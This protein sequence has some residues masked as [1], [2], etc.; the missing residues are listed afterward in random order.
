MLVFCVWLCGCW[1]SI[2]SSLL[3]KARNI[4]MRCF[5][6]LFKLE[7]IVDA[8]RSM[9]LYLLASICASG[10]LH[11]NRWIARPKRVEGIACAH[12]SFNDIIW[13]FATKKKSL[14]FSCL[15]FIFAQNKIWTKIRKNHL[16]SKCVV[17]LLNNF[18]FAENQWMK[19]V[20]HHRWMHGKSN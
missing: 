20:I 14:I 17:L 15:F 7:T 5:I 9:L 18:S 16:R 1:A 6:L 13:I 4:E 12:I 19:W 3:S 10:L 11:D 2:Q 8:S